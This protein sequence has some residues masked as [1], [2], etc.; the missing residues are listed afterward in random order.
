MNSWPGQAQNG[1]LRSLM[2]LRPRLATNHI[3]HNTEVREDIL[4]LHN[5]RELCASESRKQ[6]KSFQ[7]MMS[8]NHFWQF[9]WNTCQ[10]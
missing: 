1:S 4:I 3:I 10:P 6:I 9:M 5:D 7:A 8:D 2:E